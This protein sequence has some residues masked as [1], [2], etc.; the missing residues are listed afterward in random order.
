MSNI[1]SVSYQLVSLNIGIKTRMEN[2]KQ[3]FYSAIYKHPVPGS[4]YLSKTGFVG[5]EQA[6]QVHHGGVDK[7]VCVFNY[8]AYPDYET[9]LEQTLKPGAFG[10]N[11]TVSG[12]NEQDIHIG[13]ILKLGESTVQ[14][15][16]PRVPCFK[17]GVKYNCKELP[18][19][20]QTTGI[21]G[22]YFR[23]LEEGHVSAE[24][25]LVLTSR[26]SGS[27]SVMEA[28]RIMHHSKQDIQAI[29]RLL[30]VDTLADSWKS[31]LNKRLAKL[32]ST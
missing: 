21:T 14:V 9:F 24:D 13:D 17:L 31:T 8:L 25:E 2:G 19:Q 29:E 1:Q 18:L 10:E 32:I 11:I 30:S 26:E 3:D 27:V 6:D 16:Q 28:N 5:D 23:V 15:S 20:F 4:T 12:C 22:Y 7:A